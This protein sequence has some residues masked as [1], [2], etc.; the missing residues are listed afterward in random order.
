MTERSASG[1]GFGAGEMAG[2]GRSTF[3]TAAE[4]RRDFTPADC[5]EEA[6]GRLFAYWN[7]RRGARRFPARRDLDPIE[8]RYAL[9]GITLFDVERPATA[10]GKPRFRYRLI[11]S[12]IVAR[13][14]FDFTGR[15]LDDLPLPQYRTLLLARLEMLI[16]DPAP[17]LI[18]N[19]QFYDE[20]W[21]DYEAIWLPLAEDGETPDIM[22]ACQIF[23]RTPS[24]HIGP[25][26]SRDD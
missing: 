15:Y 1:D 20:R 12:D 17:R 11:G 21:Y 23:S 19:K 18:R 3:S 25:L 14:G 16:R 2:T 22:M 24:A 7:D 9:G 6:I 26:L 10:E 8:M 5:R 4:M 13:D